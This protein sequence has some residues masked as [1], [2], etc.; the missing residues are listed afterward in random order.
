MTSN[1]K[2]DKTHKVAENMTHNMKYQW[3]ETD[4]EITQMIDFVEKIFEK[5]WLYL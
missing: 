2:N 3:A 4:P 5:L 1:K